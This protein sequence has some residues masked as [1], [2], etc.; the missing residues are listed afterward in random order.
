MENKNLLVL[1]SNDNVA[2]ALQKFNKGVDLKAMC[3]STRDLIP[4]GHKIALK[5]MLPGDAIVKYGQVIGVATKYIQPGEHV[6]VH[7]MDMA[8]YE[9]SRIHGKL[10]QETN[11]VPTFERSVFEGYRR[12]S[13]KVGT[14]NYVG[15]VTSVN[16]S[17]S[18]AKHLVRE[19]EKSGLLE[20][21][22]N[23]DGI[24]PIIHGAGCCIGTDDEAFRKLQSAIWGYANH[25][26]FASVLLLGLG[27][28][29][30][31]IPLM[32]ETYGRA[33]DDSFQY[34]TLQDVGGTRKSVE[35]GL[36]WL[37]IALANANQAQRETVDVGH[38]CVALQCGGSDGYSGITAN[39]AL[40]YAV[41]L[42]IKN[43]G[44]AALAE[45]PEIYGAEHLLTDR[46][47]STQV[48]DKLINLLEWWEDYALKHDSAMN[49]NPTPGNK[50]GG[51]TTILE[52][53][54]GAVAKAGSTNL[55]GVYRYGEQI[56]SRGLVFVDSPGYDPVS[57][58]GQ[59]ASG[60]NLICFTTGRGSCYGNKPV[61][62][63]KIASN[64]VMYKNMIDDMDLN[65]GEIAQGKETVEEAGQRIYEKILKTASGQKTRSETLDVGDV[66]FAP[67]QT[68]A[69]M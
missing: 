26:N 2:V 37:E 49:N 58:T 47:A 9:R 7:N 6:H 63:I 45:T 57:I 61:P 18:A 14:R 65:C 4:S 64:T 42:L 38:I 17:A 8:E 62:S 51:L 41:D 44:T 28:E 1:N 68:Y 52:K 39:P 24:V 20:Q 33:N 46:A 13:G 11:L 36:Q 23:V 48:G 5:K 12:K 66:E 55:N 40:G 27:C 69:Q 35:K 54:L 15:I 22:P 19:A 29:A 30:N 43:G 60:C 53:S 50:A 25:P 21:Y 59:V 67:W 16:C 3:F 32:L 34:Y 10:A 31:Q 56:T